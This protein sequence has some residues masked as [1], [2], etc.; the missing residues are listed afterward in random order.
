[1]VPQQAQPGAVVVHQPV[2]TGVVPQPAPIEAAHPLAHIEVEVDLQLAHTAVVVAHQGA[3][4]VLLLDLIGAA[5]AQLE[6]GA[7]LEAGVEVAVVQEVGAAAEA[8]LP[9]AEVDLQEAG[10]D[11]GVAVALGAGVGLAPAV[12]VA[13]PEAAVAHAAGAAAEV[14]H[15][16]AALVQ[17]VAVAHPEAAVVRAAA[18]GVAV[19]VGHG[20]EVDPP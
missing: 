7:A 20:A 14:G 9:G 13:Q 2:L 16:V 6:V 8:A 5:V 15:P 4:V 1:M 3:E 12:E 10:V 19:E 11:P 18:A 17:E